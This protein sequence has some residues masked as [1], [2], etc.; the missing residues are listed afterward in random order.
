MLFRCVEYLGEQGLERR[1]VCSLFLAKLQFGTFSIQNPRLG[2]MAY[3]AREDLS[4]RYNTQLNFV[5]PTSC[6]EY[7]VPMIFSHEG[8]H[9]V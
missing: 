1:T 4:N 6:W 3:K 5:G 7:G 2:S 8:Q 9:I